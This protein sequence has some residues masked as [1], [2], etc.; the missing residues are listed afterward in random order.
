MTTS[1]SRSPQR[2]QSSQGTQGKV[3]S[4][5][6]TC[7][8][9]IVSSLFWS[10][11]LLSHGSVTTTVLFDREVVRILDK[12]CVMCHSEGSLS[13]PL[14]T[15]EQ[16]W[17]QGKKIRAGVLARHMPPWAAVAGYGQFANENR[18]TLR[19]T[20]FIVS[21]VEGLGPRNSGTVFANVVDGGTRPPAIRALAHTGHWMLGEPD[22]TRPLPANTIAPQ[23]PD[24]IR[25][26]VID[27]D[28]KEERR[29]RALE[30]MPGDRRVVR[31]AFFTVQET[32]Q[33]IG[34]WTPWHGMMELPDGTAHRLPAGSHVV[35]EIHYRSASETAVD[36]GTLGL[37]FTKASR[38][39]VVS[40]LLLD[41]KRAAPAG[42]AQRLRAEMLLTADTRALALWPEVASGPTSIEVAARKPDGS[43][44]ILLFV[45]N[46]A[47]EWPTPYIFGA[48]TLLRKG[49]KLLV[50]AY[51]TTPPPDGMRIRV[52]R[53]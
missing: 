35:A 29:V 20:Q 16:T 27:L 44:D 9:V 48:P 47:V 17:L 13:F 28:L 41:A 21:W 45:K 7:A 22:L 23:Q 46:P 3:L 53:Y 51:Y 36:G 19:E 30:Y 26:T 49:T 12:H 42:A 33:W 8:A 5:L 4:A 1:H 24:G 34:S 43:T 11:A 52:S 31:A 14:E 2:T 37:F 50:V 15:Y 40:D 6:S 39:S 32:G 25:R 38:T 18:L 10:Q